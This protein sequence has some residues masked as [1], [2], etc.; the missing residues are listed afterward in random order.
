LTPIQLSAQRLR[1]KYGER[2]AKEDGAVFDECTRLIIDNVEELKVLVNEFSNFARMPASSPVPDNIKQIIQ[3]AILLYKDAHK[4]ITFEFIDNYDIPIFRLD[5]E[6]V[7][8]VM[9][10]LLDNAVA[11]ISGR[12]NVSIRLLYDKVLRIVR[13]EVADTG[14]GIPNEDRA[15][16]FEPYFSTKK[17]GTGL[18]LAIASRIIS[19]HN[20]SIRVEDNTPKGTKFIIELP[21]RV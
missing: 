20:G 17:S 21:V 3:D 6:H 19:D 2:L 12:G 10:N 5:K 8:R 11:A 4:S 13:I 1:R 7:K 14:T 16:L 18:G 9:I 15:H